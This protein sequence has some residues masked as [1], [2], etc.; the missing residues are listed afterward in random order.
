MG[1]EGRKKERKRKRPR[2]IRGELEEE[3]VVVGLSHR[4]DLE[5][6]LSTTDEG[7]KRERAEW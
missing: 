2:K 3:A 7:R 6:L 4:E 1:R 5:Y